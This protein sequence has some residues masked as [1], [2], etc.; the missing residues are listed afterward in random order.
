MIIK[1]KLYIQ[2][3]KAMYQEEFKVQVSTFKRTS[4]S[5]TGQVVID[6]DEDSV[7]VHCP[8][9]TQQDFTLNHVEQLRAMRRKMIADNEVMLMA[10][11]EQ[12]NSL[13][14]IENKE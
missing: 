1:T 12:I 3:V 4:D 10:I 7:D 8:D 9:F 11:D 13:L 6:I 5:I 14:A 2:A